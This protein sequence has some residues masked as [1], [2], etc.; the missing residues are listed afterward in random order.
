MVARSAKFFFG[1]GSGALIFRRG[2]RHLCGGC[3]GRCC[4]EHCGAARPAQRNPIA[5]LRAGQFFSALLT[6][7]IGGCGGRRSPERQRAGWRPD[8]KD[9]KAQEPA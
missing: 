6:L 2:D 1:E 9:T 8:R 7:S 5:G 3:S 4:P